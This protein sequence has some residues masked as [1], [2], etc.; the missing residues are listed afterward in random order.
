M[1]CMVIG[2][3]FQFLGPTW[4]LKRLLSYVGREEAVQ[5]SS[6]GGQEEIEGLYTSLEYGL[7]LVILL[8]VFQ[9]SKILSMAA[10]QTMSIHTGARMTGALQLMVYHRLLTLRASAASTDQL[11]GKLNTIV[12]NDVERVYEAIAMAPMIMN[13][14][15]IFI[16]CLGYSVYVM[17]PWALLGL[18]VILISLPIL[19]G[20]A[21]MV[22]RIRRETVPYTEARVGLTREI[23]SSVRLI[24][25]YVWEE[26]FAK[27]V[28]ELRKPEHQRLRK[29]A[30]YQ[31]IT[32]VIISNISVIAAVITFLGF[33]LAGNNFSA[34]E[35][36]TVL[37][38]F[39]AFQFALGTLPH[40]VRCV[41]EA[42]VCLGRMRK[43]L[44]MSSPP[45]R[46]P[47]YPRE[48]SNALELEEVTFVVPVV[49]REEEEKAAGGRGREK[50]KK[51]KDAGLKRRNELVENGI[52]ETELF[53]QE[54]QKLTVESASSGPKEGTMV[55]VS[56]PN[57]LG[58]PGEITEVA[59]IP[60]KKATFDVRKG[61][62]VG[63]TGGVGSGKSC[64]LAGIAG[65]LSCTTGHFRV[66]GSIAMVSQTGWIFNETIREN[67]TF[68]LTFDDER[69]S[70]VLRAT[71]LDSDLADLPH[72]DQ[73]EIGERGV[74]LSGGQKQ[75]VNLARAVYANRDIYLLD[76][77][78]SAV[79]G[80]VATDIFNRCI[81]QLLKGKTILLVT[82]SVTLL[83]QCDEVLFVSEGFVKERGTHSDLLGLKGGYHELVTSGK[84]SRKS[85]R[86]RR[87]RASGGRD[88][89]PV[90][91]P[92]DSKGDGVGEKEESFAD[93]V[94]KEMGLDPRDM[95]LLTS[96]VEDEAHDE[97]REKEASDGAID[98]AEDSGKLI[99]DEEMAV[100][101]IPLYVYVHFLSYC[102]MVS[103]IGVFLAIILFSIFRSA[104]SIFLQIWIDAGDGL[105]AERLANM[106]ALVEQSTT[107]LPFLDNVTLSDSDNVTM[108]TNETD[109]TSTVGNTS[110]EEVLAYFTPQ[111]ISGS[112]VD[113]PRLWMYQLVF[114]CLTVVTVLVG[115]AQSFLCVRQVLHGSSRMHSAMFKS[116]LRAPMSFFDATPL[117]RILNRFARDIDEL[118]SRQP[119]FVNFVTIGIVGVVVQLLV[120]CLYY[121]S[122]ILPFVVILGL[123]IFLDHWLNAGVREMK[124]LDNILTSF[125]IHHL[126]STVSGLAVIHSYHRELAFER[127]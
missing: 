6:S 74:N 4:L 94:L 62:L 65:E 46:I 69:Y 77:T 12:T 114:F 24:K 104:I 2:S 18:L 98:A 106:S 16:L 81:K 33:S 95:D 101:K 34:P 30:F 76:D 27:K 93:E 35:V 53:P 127:K 38:L 75:R 119:F 108:F 80:R 43:L 84:A 47:E 68:G 50:K 17:G 1:L 15:V 28:L 8:V 13:T 124:R 9:L 37:S 82:H 56:K 26:P 11:Y 111:Q 51:K 54:M 48:E 21:A 58:A 88:L 72:G 103:M 99:R 107:V 102:G 89:S 109:E 92:L 23:L 63:V 42:V 32:M 36:F 40:T 79:D 123:F 125:V 10:M 20:I 31:S 29:A 60:V 115:L 112:V 85:R 96:D 25:S 14:P 5:I 64:L 44:L 73:T 83:E 49:I 100:G 52:T 91:R 126:S 3:F 122:F 22:G 86:R 67:V 121:P 19:S 90:L 117:G 113:N 110:L 70:E 41:A 97:S 57:E 55:V 61:A 118:D 71:C 78:L 116:V 7:A 120:V 66:S 45:P 39:G 59:A 105:K 87:V